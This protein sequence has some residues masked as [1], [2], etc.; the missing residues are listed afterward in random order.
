MATALP[1]EPPTGRIVV[2]PPPGLEPD[3][4]AAGVLTGA[5]PMLG[6]L[7]SVALVA[8]MAT[9][10]GTTGHRSLLAAGA[11]L[12]GT[13]CFVLVQLDRQRAR[14]LRRR[15]HAR[16]GYLRHLA[17]VRRR[18][19]LA[20]EQQRAALTWHHPHP[21]ALPLRAASGRLHRRDADRPDRLEVRYGAGDRPAAVELEP[22]DPGAG[23]DPDPA[24]LDA[25]R[26]LLAAHALVPG[27]PLTLD[28]RGHERVVVEG[29]PDTA[30]SLARAV[31]AQAAAR[32]PPDRLVVA[33]LAEPETGPGWDWL[34]WLPHAHSPHA[35]DAAGPRRLVASS[36][37]ELDG[38][39]PASGHLLL[40]ADGPD[41]G[42]PAA[43]PDG[44]TVLALTPSG[45][46]H[47]QALR[48]RVDAAGTV[49]ALDGRSEPVR[50]SAD[51]CDPATAE[52]LARR[53]L[54]THP[55]RAGAVGPRAATDALALLGLPG[56]ADVDPTR[57]WCSRPERE[58]LRVPLG[59][60]DDG[61]PLHLD[62]KEAAR[63]GVGPHGLV[64]G[65]TGSGKSEL[66]RTLVLGLTLT[67]PPD[68]LNLV[69]VDFKGGATFAGLA[70]LPH[71]AAMVTNLADDLGLVGRMQ[72]ALTAELLRRQELLRTAG[73]LASVRDLDRAR[74]AGADAPALPTL[75]VVVDEFAEMLVARPEF[76][77]VFGA[78]GRLGRSLGIHLLLATQRLEEG[79][80]RGLESHLSY[81]IGLRTFSGAES[82]AVLGVPDAAGLPALPGTGLLRT[83]PDEP[84]RFRAAYVSGAAAERPAAAAPDVL[85]FTLAERPLPP[86]PPGATEPT[87]GASL[88]DLAVARLAGHGSPAH[89]VWLP[90]LDRPETLGGLL[91]G[92]TADP[93]RGLVAAGARADP[94]RLPLGTVDRPREQRQEP[95]VVDLGGAG[96]HVAVVG[97]PRSG[98]TTLVQTLVTGLALTHTPDEA[99]VLVVDLGGGG[100]AAL[101]G[102]P[103]VAVV[104]SRA[105]PDVVRRVVAH[106]RAVLDRR[107]AW[108]RDH[109]IADIAGYRRLLRSG[110][111]GDGHGEVFL[112][113]D[114]W[115]DLRADHDDLEPGLQQLAA[116][117][118]A[119]GVHLVVATGR[120]G[121]LRAGMR[122]LLGTRVEL[123]LG[124]PLDS[125]VDRRAARLVPP[126]RPGRGLT[127]TGHHVLTALPRI[128]GDSDP[129]S[130]AAGLADLVDRV[131]A[132]WPGAPAPRVGRLPSEVDLA[133]VR[134]LAGDPGC[135]LLGVDDRVAVGLDPASE[136]HLLV[137]G[138]RRSGRTT[139][140]RTLALEVVRTR[141]PRRAQL[142]VV[143][144]RRTL[145][146]EVPGDHLLAHHASP[147]TAAPALRE[148]ADHLRGRL[149]G[150]EITP[151]QLRSRSWWS[152]AEV[153]VLVDDHEL[154]VAAGGSPLAPLLPLLPHATDVG[155]R[156]VVARRT[157]GAS[158]ALH[159]PD[160]RALRDLAAPT[161]LL[162][163]GADEG[164]LVGRLTP[165][166]GPPGRGRLVTADGTV[167]E[168][169]VARVAPRD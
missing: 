56:V 16:R 46:G 18:A 30:R 169:Q 44:L 22:P 128:D 99:Q 70:P 77:E 165:R 112:V 13:L 68:R 97:A 67:H 154:L 1:P 74:D 29:D 116:R 7:G 89:P 118:L 26:R 27:L 73:D 24:A 114:G 166:P 104:A 55:V 28:L 72:D 94:L 64:V 90:P 159:E 75:L 3:E 95:L 10:S 71:V 15:D 164:P 162:P 91:G 57:S 131:A 12:L 147:T 124:D 151:A 61:R 126:D 127:P 88:L 142:V 58:R 59:V 48:L 20:A 11:F 158:R 102:L 121:D 107:E 152:G 117:G 25:L 168:L 133:E 36:L 37:V 122:D 111:Q 101:A 62:L 155:L 14:R 106:V 98:R 113:V 45:A 153:H 145:L 120:W 32:H 156:L 157:T 66:L 144:P 42:E 60:T 76:V 132:A 123:R 5:V 63:G 143:D 78:I 85:P 69:L 2:D 100:L 50:G 129:G 21:G 105:E 134:T 84:V 9:P 137:L 65:A 8:T 23:D 108:W 6:S 54:R 140:L 161:L 93:R 103:H 4:G 39:L 109:G 34:K 135:L 138:D 96:G 40:V 79:R 141:T 148:L 160:L 35:R 87:A 119:L 136:P 83:G 80:L 86:A 110:G 81:R 41:V 19:R 38:L 51:R 53:L 130:A 43:R 115:A 92:L 49:T 82:R 150:P 47:E 146:G 17:D 163:G 33:L 52:A 149:P 125:E 167:T 139:T 31:V